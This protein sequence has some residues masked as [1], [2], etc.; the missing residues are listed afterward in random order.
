MAAYRILEVIL[1]VLSP[2]VVVVQLVTTFVLG[3]LISITFGL[4][5]LPL[6][7]VWL[8]LLAPMLAASWLCGR[9]GALRNPIGILG[10]PW[11]VLASTYAC[12]VTS[13]GEFE[14]RALK[15]MLAESWPFTWELWRFSAG[16][17]DVDSIAGGPF[18]VVLERV[19]RGDA[20]RQRTLDRLA[21]RQPLDPD[22]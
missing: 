15:I 13:M 17:L 20:I 10:I 12:W 8:L 18:D 7:A 22:V 14:S 2:V 6:S 1:A 16:R 9:V 5:L 19:S 11:A 21:A 4:L 3:I